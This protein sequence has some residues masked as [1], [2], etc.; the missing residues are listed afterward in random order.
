MH[1]CSNKF[2]LTAPLQL[3]LQP[4]EIVAIEEKKQIE[5]LMI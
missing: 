2:Y 3:N 5:R 1:P 4:F